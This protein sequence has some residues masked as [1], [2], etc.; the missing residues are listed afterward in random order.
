MN[1]IPS[2]QNS[3]YEIMKSLQVGANG[4]EFIADTEAHSASFGA[5]QVLSDA[6]FHTLEG[7]LVEL[8]NTTVGSAPSIEAGTVLYGNFSSIKLHSGSVV[9]YNSAS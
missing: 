1:S 2:E 8:A 6:K 9:A 7:N 4:G 5:I 3:L